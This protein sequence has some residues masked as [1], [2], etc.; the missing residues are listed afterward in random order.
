MYFFL[1]VYYTLKIYQIGIKVNIIKDNNQK[2]IKLE[3]SSRKTKINIC[4]VKNVFYLQHENEK[5]TQLNFNTQINFCT[6]V[7]IEIIL[8]LKT[9]TN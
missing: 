3:S 6:E 4:H 5:Q 7:S 8:H 1:H 9:S 2:N